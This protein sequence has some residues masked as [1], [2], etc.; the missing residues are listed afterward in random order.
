MAVPLL[1]NVWITDA[2]LVQRRT[3]TRGKV[4]GAWPDAKQIY[5]KDGGVWQ[6][7]WVNAERALGMLTTSIF[8]FDFTS[9]YF[10]EAGWRMLFDGK[11]QSKT[12]AG[13]YTDRADPWLKY[14]T[15]QHLY[16]VKFTKIGL[17]NLDIT[18]TL[19]TYIDCEAG[20]LEFF[21]SVNLKKLEVGEFTCDF[22]DRAAPG[23]APVIRSMVLHVEADA[24]GFA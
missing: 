22:I 3:W 6:T 8:D 14:D 23:P 17:E 21:T 20:T 16:Q 9:P 11:S 18:P 24:Q 13:S 7:A 19:A 4:G 1:V 2:G 12:G 5:V 15:A 10:A